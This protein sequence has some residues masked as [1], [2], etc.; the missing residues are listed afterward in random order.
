VFQRSSEKEAAIELLRSFRLD[1]PFRGR[2]SAVEQFETA[3]DAIN[4]PV[5]GSTDPAQTSLI[6]MREAIE[7]ALDHLLHMRPIRTNIGNVQGQNKDWRKIVAIA[8]QL[9]KDEIPESIFQS[10]ARDWSNLKSQLL[11]P[12]KTERI[13]RAEWGRRISKATRFVI[14]FLSGLDAGKI[15]HP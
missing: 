5:T 12:A 3:Y 7:T 6:P 9:K 15:D 1:E 10:W 8:I 13:D 4:R 11:S 14:A 2:R